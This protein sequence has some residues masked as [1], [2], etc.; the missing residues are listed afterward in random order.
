MPIRL[1]DFS[2]KTEFRGQFPYLGQ[3]VQDI[4]LIAGVECQS[5]YQTSVQK[6]SFAVSFLIWTNSTGYNIYSACRMPIRLPEIQH[7]VF[8]I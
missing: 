4:R 8:D 2:S 6:L 1:P 7:P 3:T 5:N